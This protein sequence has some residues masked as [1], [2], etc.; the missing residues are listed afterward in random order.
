MDTTGEQ[1]DIEREAGVLLTQL[2]HTE[3]DETG[4]TRPNL[5]MDTEMVLE[6]CVRE[7]CVPEKEVD[8]QEQ[9]VINSLETTKDSEVWRVPDGGWGWMVAIGSFIAMVSLYSYCF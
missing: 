5:N 3:S 2:H 7:T 1:E 9:G 6:D 8:L 4:H